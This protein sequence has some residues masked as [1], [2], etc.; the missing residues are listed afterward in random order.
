MEHA[1]EQLRN[2]SK[3][4]KTKHFFEKINKKIEVKNIFS[5][6]VSTEIYIERLTIFSN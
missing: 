4:S 3:K 5:R 6:N 1:G 2:G